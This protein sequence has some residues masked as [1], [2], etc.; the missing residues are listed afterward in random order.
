MRTAVLA[1][2]ANSQHACQKAE[3]VENYALSILTCF[4]F[5]FSMSSIQVRPAT[6][7]DAKA[8][9]QIHTAS[10]LEAYR[11]LLPDDQLKSM[12]SVEKRQAY[13]REA[14]EYCEPQ[15]QVAIEGDKIVG[16]VGF[17]R[18]RDEKS[19]QTTGE[20]WAIYAA[21]AH[22]NQGVGV[23][24]WDAA[25]DGLMEEGC[26]N[27]TAWVPLRNERALRFHEMAGFKREMSTAKTAVI[28]SIKIE[29]VR[30]KRPLN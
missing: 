16:F 21:P 7:R 1:R 20:I 6:L 17:D 14:I 8:I 12:S 25:R 29:E 30:L 27:V 13:W 23:A 3:F 10:A 5:G 26:T 15:V 11:G 19:R 18:S 22:W 9:A 2:M 4:C 24:L 28:G